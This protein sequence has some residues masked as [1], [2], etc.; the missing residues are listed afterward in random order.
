MWL[1]L[2]LHLNYSRGFVASE[3][4]LHQ[5]NLQQQARIN[6]GHKQ[7]SIQKPR[8]VIA[9]RGRLNPLPG[10]VDQ[11]IITPLSSQIHFSPC[12]ISFSVMSRFVWSSAGTK[13]AEI[14]RADVIRSVG[15][16][17]CGRESDK[18]RTECVSVFPLASHSSLFLCHHFMGINKGQVT[19]PQNLPCTTGEE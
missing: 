9:K 18:E 1:P 11:Y 8:Q 7:T 16:W 2:Y 12:T 3:F 5:K 14:F 4:R 6:M 19:T 17:F 13:A 10:H 15:G